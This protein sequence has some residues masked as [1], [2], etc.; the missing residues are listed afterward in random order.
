MLLGGEIV[1]L[2]ADP[3]LAEQ[4]LITSNSSFQKQ[5]TAFFPNSDFTGKGLLVSDG[6]LW[7][8]Q[9]RLSSKAFRESAIKVYAEEMAYQAEKMLL[10]HLWS[11]AGSKR[12]DVY[13]DY[14]KLTL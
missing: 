10:G 14:N 6:A 5:G 3:D 1:T 4:V 8:R 9:R 7:Q 11:E 2:V 13:A 12:R